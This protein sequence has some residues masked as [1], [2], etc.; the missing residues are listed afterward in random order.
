MFRINTSKFHVCYRSCLFSYLHLT[1]HSLKFYLLLILCLQIM[2]KSLHSH[3]NIPVNTMLLIQTILK[4]TFLLLKNIHTT[5]L[6]TFNQT[7]LRHVY[8]SVSYISIIFHYS[9]SFCYM[10]QF[11]LI[12]SIISIAFHWTNS[13]S[14]TPSNISV[15]S[16]HILNA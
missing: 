1:Q 8:C 12:L 3:P 9:C 16:N 4:L 7:T 5:F 13:I 2:L 15:L 10:Y 6:F 11:D 14:T